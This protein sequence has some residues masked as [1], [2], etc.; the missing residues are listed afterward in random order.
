MAFQADHGPEFRAAHTSLFDSNALSIREYA[1]GRYA[2]ELDPE[3]IPTFLAETRVLFTEEWS[4]E[5]G[6]EEQLSLLKQSLDGHG[7]L[8]S[9]EKWNDNADALNAKYQAAVERVPTDVR[10]NSVV[11]RFASGLVFRTDADHK[12]LYFIHPSAAVAQD[13]LG[14]EAG[15]DKRSGGGKGQ[16]DFETITGTIDG[17]QF[18]SNSLSQEQA[19]KIIAY[20]ETAFAAPGAPTADS[21][22]S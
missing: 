5:L 18:R 2:V 16:P 10:E 22:V 11:G 21:R 20:F 4:D 6:S 17:E 7:R 3:S 1:D 8:R 12:Q 19:N 9:P 13:F 14:S 15:P